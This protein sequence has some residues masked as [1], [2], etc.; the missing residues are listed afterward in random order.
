MMLQDEDAL[1]LN[2]IADNKQYLNLGTGMPMNLL[3]SLLQIRMKQT[4]SINSREIDTKA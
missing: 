3:K 1:T 4:K 2:S